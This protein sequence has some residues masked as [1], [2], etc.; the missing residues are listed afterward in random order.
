MNL[1]L[2]R[3]KAVPGM[4]EKITQTINVKIREVIK[5]EINEDDTNFI[6]E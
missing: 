5:N 3:I 2:E 1:D 6:G 4:K